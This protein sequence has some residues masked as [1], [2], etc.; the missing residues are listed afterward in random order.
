[1]TLFLGGWYGPLLPAW[2]WFV[3]KTY[4]VFFLFFWTRGTLPR[5]RVDQLMS[6]SWKVLLPLALVNMVVTGIGITIYNAIV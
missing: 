1:M 6:F 4:G 3:V 5:V 2:L